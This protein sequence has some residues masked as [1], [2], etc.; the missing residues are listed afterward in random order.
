MMPKTEER[1]KK[2]G[3]ICQMLKKKKKQE[4]VRVL[5]SDVL[6]D[7]QH[8]STTSLSREKMLSA[9]G[10]ACLESLTVLR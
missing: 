1:Q 7:E 8:V 4:V 10:S 2:D 5:E 9:C 6:E 3:D